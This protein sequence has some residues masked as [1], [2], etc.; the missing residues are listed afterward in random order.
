MRRPLVCLALAACSAASAGPPTAAA[1]LAAAMSPDVVG[2]LAPIDPVAGDYAMSLDMRFETFPTMEMRIDDT[3]TGALTMSLGADGRARACLG[4]HGHDEVLGQ[5]EYRKNGNNEHRSSD[6]VRLLGLAGT[7]KL[8]DGVAEIRFDR[9]VWNKCD[10]LRETAEAAPRTE[11]RCIAT[12][13]TTLLPARA[14]VCQASAQHGELLDLGMPM[15][16]ASRNVPASPMHSAP[17]GL[18]LVLASPGI[19]V[20]ATQD[21]QAMVPTFAF[22]AGAVTLDEAAFRPKTK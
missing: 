18:E 17:A 3:R 12:R 21:A 22:T 13:A 16:T 15:T 4:S 2:A 1:T 9:E 6:D 14:L 7:W 5:W 8:V 10:A 11:L 20:A 19:A